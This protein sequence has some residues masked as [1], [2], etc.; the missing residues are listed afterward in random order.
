MSNKSFFDIAKNISLNITDEI[1][2]YPYVILDSKIAKRFGG[3][4][5][6]EKD[7]TT[8]ENFLN[9]LKNN[10]DIKNN[11]IL[12]ESLWFSSII[13]YAK[14]FADTEGRGGQKLDKN[15]YL[16][17]ESKDINILHDFLIDTRNKYIAHSGDNLREDVQIHLRLNNDINNKQIVNYLSYLGYLIH[18]SDTDVNKFLSLIEIIKTKLIEIINK[19]YEHLKNEVN[20]VDI[21]KWYNRA[22]FPVNKCT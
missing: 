3:L 4:L 5:L 8:V 2:K 22:V 17:K 9:K 10:C 7:L 21:S 12:K 16:K 19:T 6:I 15:K 1:E 20:L 18:F 14:C 13:I 11:K